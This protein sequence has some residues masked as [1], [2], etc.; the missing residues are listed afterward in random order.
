M[1]TLKE[2]A[3]SV[4]SQVYNFNISDD[5]DID[6]DWIYYQINLIKN[7]V[8]TEY[9]RNKNKIFE[10]DIHKYL[11]DVNC[12]KLECVDEAECCD[13]TTDCNILKVVLPTN[14][15]YPEYTSVSLVDKKK[16]FDYVPRP[17]IQSYLNRRIL[18]GIGYW[19]YVQN[20]IYVISRIPH[21]KYISISGVFEEVDKLQAITDC[22]DKP[23]FEITDTDY[24]VEPIHLPMIEQYVVQL[25]RTALVNV[26]DL[27]NNALDDA[28]NQVR[29]DMQQLNNMLN[30]LQNRTPVQ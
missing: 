2:I 9:L 1:A 8:I 11:Y 5:T 4:L 12:L 15:L 27:T 14:I 19:Y 28:I 16:Y 20:R 7:K 13:I 6:L 23:C 22:E 18:L 26:K 3:Y 30:S 10:F 17:L 21:L 29:G 24:P 25:C